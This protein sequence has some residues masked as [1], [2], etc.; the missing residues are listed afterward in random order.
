MKI[1][2]SDSLRGELRPM[3]LGKLEQ[4]LAIEAGAYSFPWTRGNFLDS[5]AAGHDMQVLLDPRGTV[6][7]YSVSILGVD[8]LHLL[9]LTVEPSCRRAGH[10]CRLLQRLIDWARSREKSAVWLEVRA[11]NEPA[12]ALYRHF[13]FAMTGV[14]RDYYPARQ[15]REDAVLMSL[16][17]PSGH[18]HR[19]AGG[20]SRSEAR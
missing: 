11:G 13:G 5:L 7:A 14:R 3:D 9:N 20:M 19:A 16:H 10:A 15:G 17:L 18:A 4:V 12:L 1:P 8:E 2:G 6:M